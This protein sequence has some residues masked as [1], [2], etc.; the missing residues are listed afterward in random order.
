M[1]Q[2]NP[3]GVQVRSLDASTVSHAT[4]Q[5][6]QFRSQLSWKPVSG[7]TLTLNLAPYSVTKIV[8]GKES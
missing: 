4:A 2:I 1:E 5:P 6:L 8:T 3:E 7:S